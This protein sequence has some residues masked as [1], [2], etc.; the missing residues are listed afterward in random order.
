MFQSGKREARKSRRG[1]ID[2]RSAVASSIYIN[3]IMNTLMRI[4]KGSSYDI[5]CV[6]AVLQYVYEIS[7]T[8]KWHI[9]GK[10]LSGRSPN[11]LTELSLNVFPNWKLKMMPGMCYV[12]RRYRN[13]LQI[14]VKWLNLIKK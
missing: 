5:L 6:I 2:K 1:S 7:C 14:V 11:E 13:Q 8:L 12:V 9:A 10:S 4:R 3:T